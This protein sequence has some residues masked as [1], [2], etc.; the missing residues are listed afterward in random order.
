[1]APNLIRLDIPGTYLKAAWC[2]PT[3]PSTTDQVV[4]LTFI[5]VITN[6]PCVINLVPWIANTSICSH[7]VLTCSI[8]ANTRSLCT[9]IDICNK[10]KDNWNGIQ[11]ESFQCF[12]YCVNVT[13]LSYWNQQT[14][15]IFCFA[16]FDDLEFLLF[17]ILCHY[18]INSSDLNSR[19]EICY[20]FPKV[21]HCI[22]L[23]LSTIALM[24]N[25]HSAYG[26]WM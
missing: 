21:A 24:G 3:L 25:I 15:M 19:N 26:W 2:V 12:K 1:M 5:D 23:Q 6:F 20:H 13:L 17:A 22:W 10:K 11:E 14:L 16:A 8:L 4:Q 7:Q 18:S 9:L